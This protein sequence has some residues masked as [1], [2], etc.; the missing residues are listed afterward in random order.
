[1]GAWTEP[2][3]AANTANPPI[4]PYNNATTTASGH[5]W[6]MDDTP[7]RERI[8]LQHRDGSFTEYHPAGNVV[9]KIVGTNFFIV[10]QDNNVLISGDCNITISGNA[11]IQVDGNAFTYVKGNSDQV[12]SGNATQTCQGDTT[13]TSSGMVSVIADTINLNASSGVNV[14]ADLNVR[15]NIL[16]SQSITATGNL[17]AG[18]NVYGTLS[19][20][21]S[22]YLTVLGIGGIAGTLIVGGT[23][24]SPDFISPSATLVSHTHTDPQGGTVGPAEG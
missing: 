6:E 1:M 15:G 12:I 9:Q 21:T 7:G 19:L 2:E 3:S 11:N 23:V 5:S 13:I 17:N 14:N 4:Y 8:R 18:M 24:T 16:S 10:A 20:Q 22:G